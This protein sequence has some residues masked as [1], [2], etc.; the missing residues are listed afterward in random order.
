RRRLKRERRGAGGGRAGHAHRLAGSPGVERG[1]ATLRF[2]RPTRAR[3]ALAVTK[4]RKELNKRLDRSRLQAR[5][6]L[7]RSLT[8][9]ASR[10][11]LARERPAL[12]AV[13]ERLLDRLRADGLAMVGFDEL[14]GDR[15]LWQ[16]LSRA[17]MATCGRGGSEG[18]DAIRP[19]E[20][21]SSASPSPT[22]QWSPARPAR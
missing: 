20:S 10:R 5:Y 15:G 13:Q 9:G 3:R 18:A 22:A 2:A 21:S 6:H 14:V 12:D 7:H 1:W 4:L 17:G 11:S 8:N 16:E 19:P